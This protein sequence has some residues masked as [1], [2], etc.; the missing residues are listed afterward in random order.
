MTQADAGV[1]HSIATMGT[2]N[3]HVSCSNTCR[4]H[5]DIGID[6]DNSRWTQSGAGK[7]HQP[8]LFIISDAQHRRRPRH[9]Q[10]ALCHLSSGSRRNAT[11]LTIYVKCHHVLSE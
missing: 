10:T 6:G 1:P 3:V 9:Q 2:S 8:T 7:L 5:C 4:L 11:H